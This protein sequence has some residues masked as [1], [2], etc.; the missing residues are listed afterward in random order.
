MSDGLD[1]II[2]DDDQNVCELL[3]QII[4][5]FY[6]WGDVYVFSDVNEAMYYCMNR[7]SGIVIF[8]VDVFLGDISG[9]AFLDAMVEKYVGAHEDAIVITG[10]ASDDVVNMCVASGVNHLLEKPV[11]PYALQFAVRAITSKYLNFLRRLREN[12]NF[13]KE[14]EKF[15]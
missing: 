13:F 14:C 12:A 11:R 7:D 3:A 2:V 8:V 6:A 4:N 10:D 5:R 9:F 1:V 15:S